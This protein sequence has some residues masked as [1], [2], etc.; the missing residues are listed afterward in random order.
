MDS[1]STWEKEIRTQ[2]VMRKQGNMLSSN[3]DT[4][5]K[6]SASQMYNHV[7]L[8]SYC[9]IT[10]Q[11]PLILSAAVQWVQ[12]WFKSTQRQSPAGVLLCAE[13]RNGRQDQFHNLSG[14]VL[15][16][17]PLFLV[18]SGSSRQPPL[19]PFEATS[20][21][22]TRHGERLFKRHSAK[23]GRQ[24]VIFNQTGVRWSDSGSLTMTWWAGALLNGSVSFRLREVKSRLEFT[25]F[26]SGEPRSIGWSVLVRLMVLWLLNGREGW[27]LSQSACRQCNGKNRMRFAHKSTPFLCLCA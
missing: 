17:L 15:R 18:V 12:R 9:Y 22:E 7:F 2:W 24:R 23:E 1:D 4:W 11:M 14:C 3:N 6:C 20:C 19:T 13:R 8:T 5:D 27:S 21:G 10:Q 16:S 26:A 25:G